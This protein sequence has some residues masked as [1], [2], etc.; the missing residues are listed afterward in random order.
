MR[1][2]L[3]KKEVEQ[4]IE[5]SIR[6]ELSIDYRTGMAVEINTFSTNF[7]EISTYERKEQDE[8]KDDGTPK[9]E[10]DGTV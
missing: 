8:D 6:N 4:I 3:T 1:I 2:I 9:E 7:A 10:T 5:H